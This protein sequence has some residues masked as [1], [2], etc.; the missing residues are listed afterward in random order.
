MNLYFVGYRDS[1][2]AVARVLPDGTVAGGAQIQE[3]GCHLSW[4]QFYIDQTGSAWTLCV[5]Y[6]GATVKRYT[7]LNSI[8]QPLPE[9]AKQ[10]ADVIWR[11]GA[12]INLSN[13]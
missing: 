6:Q 12:Q 5:N 7:L 10:P 8:G 3:Q 4:R 2:M 1:G 13:A 11:P 9:A